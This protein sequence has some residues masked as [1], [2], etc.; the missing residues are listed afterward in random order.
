MSTE[1]LLTPLFED[2]L[3]LDL[4]IFY[5]VDYFCK[6]LT[7]ACRTFITF[8]FIKFTVVSKIVSLVSNTAI[9]DSFTAHVHD[10]VCWFCSCVTA[11]SNVATLSSNAASDLKAAML[12][13]GANIANAINKT[14]IFCL[15]F[16]IIFLLL[17]NFQ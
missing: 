10:C 8:C 2:F 15:I 17:I 3:I 4:T 5:P 7:T 14:V 12:V 11:D 6:K 9:L 13:A 16:F 1:S